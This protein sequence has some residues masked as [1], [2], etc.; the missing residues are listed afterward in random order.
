MDY[1][2]TLADI[3]QILKDKDIYSV[4]Q[5]EIKWVDFMNAYPMMFFQIIDS[6]DIDMDI[7][8]SMVEKIKKVDKQELSN[9]DA[10]ISL[11]NTLAEKYIYDKIERPT[12]SEMKVAYEK[13]KNKEYTNE[14]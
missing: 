7:V 5:M 14:S 12:E 11:G 4:R 9:E 6:E 13:M 1:E 8:R 3:E 2:K 10:E